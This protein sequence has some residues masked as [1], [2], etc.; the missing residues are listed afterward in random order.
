MTGWFPFLQSFSGHV[1]GR[2][3][4]RSETAG[5]STEALCVTRRRS[6]AVPIT[7]VKT[8]P[9]VRCGVTVFSDTAAAAFP[10]CPWVPEAVAQ[11]ARDLQR[12]LPDWMIEGMMTDF[13]RQV[14]KQKLVGSGR[15]GRSW[16]GTSEL[17]GRASLF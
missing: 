17:H 3:S 6:E 2:M 9:F 15:P 14:L 12:I 10:A 13:D 5:V 7:G 11:L 8:A 4:Y 16:T 1:N